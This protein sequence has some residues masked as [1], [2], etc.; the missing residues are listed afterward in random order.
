MKRII[1]SV[2]SDLSTDQRV[3]KVARACCESGLDVLLIGRKLPTSQTPDLPCRYK[4]LRLL[5]NRSFFFYAE[6]NLRL[7]LKL[8]F[9]RADIFL[10]NDTDTLTANFLAGKIRRKKL[11]FDAHE[12]F[13]EVPEL[14]KRNGV[15]RF[16]TR[17]EDLFFPKL[18]YAYTVSPS[19]AN[20]Y[21]KKYGVNMQVVRNIPELNEHLRPLEKFEKKTIIYQGALNMGR[22]LEWI[23]RAMPEIKDAELLIIGDGDIREQLIELTK[24][25][26]VEH[27]VKF[28]GKLAPEELKEITPRAH[29]GL[30]LLEE[31][32]LSYYYSLPNRI[33]DYIHAGIPVLATNFP[34]IR[35]IVQKHNTGILINRY[36]PQFLS[37]TVNKIL[38]SGF[39]TFHFA[40]L[41]KSLN[42]ENEKKILMEIIM[43]QE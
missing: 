22:G 13:P 36:D 41:S 17:L 14:T 25:L 3:Q 9:I 29:L 19:I 30:C 11:V 38:R 12:L 39:N 34:E 33:F 20:Y 10:A 43:A 5:F 32:G 40:E 1:I 42:W 6:Y 31:N 27:K 18:K 7:F 35:A 24:E 2:T 8:L 4:R 21:R 16:W 26:K 15:K 23:I 37:D 28:A